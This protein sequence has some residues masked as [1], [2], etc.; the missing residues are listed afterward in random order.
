MKNNYKFKDVLVQNMFYN[1]FFLH[2]NMN[3]FLAKIVAA[4]IRNVQFQ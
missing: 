3:L 1:T 2:S 4:V